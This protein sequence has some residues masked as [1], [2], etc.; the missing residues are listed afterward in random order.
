MNFVSK[1]CFQVNCHPI[2]SERM[3][4][5]GE[6]II[7]NDRPVVLN[8]LQLVCLCRKQIETFET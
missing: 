8:E 6:V 4:D 1:L 7:D 3:M 5:F 2:S